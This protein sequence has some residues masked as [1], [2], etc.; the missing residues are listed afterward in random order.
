MAFNQRGSPKTFWS[1]TAMTKMTNVTNLTKRNSLQMLCAAMS[2]V[3]A[4]NV[5]AQTDAKRPQKNNPSSA[6]ETDVLA[7]P[8]V[9]EKAERGGGN[10]MGPQGQQRDRRDNELPFQQWMASLSDLQLTES[11]QRSVK[12][13][14]DEFRVAQ[15]EY[16]ESLGEDNR[17]LLRQIRE[18]RES[19]SP[20]PEGAR[21]KLRKI[22]DERPK[23]TA[24][25]QRIWAELTA[26]QQEQLKQN[27]AE[28]KQQMAERRQQRQREGGDM[29]NPQMS[30]KPGAPMDR[31]Y[32]GHR[33]RGN[34]T[35]DQPTEMKPNGESKPSVNQPGRRP[36]GKGKGQGR[37]DERARRRMEFLRSKQATDARAPGRQPTPEDRRFE[38]EGDD[39]PAKKSRE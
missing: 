4:A 34:S 22:E 8:K 15:R 16:Q 10:M 14:A 1:T 20:P 24:Y 31:M 23:P 36:A 11:Q 13:I 28:R 30:D 9:D 12:A 27:L 26:E 29:Q 33:R 21:E 5:F 32:E 25:Q 35:S 19:G 37:T 6:G 3:C 39:K 38:F 18:A 2:L 17:A 7:G